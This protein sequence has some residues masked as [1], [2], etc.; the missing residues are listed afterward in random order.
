MQEYMQVCSACNAHVTFAKCSAAL[1]LQQANL[2]TAHSLM[3]YKQ[4][5]DNILYA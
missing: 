1:L 3:P 4:D 2:G 5:I